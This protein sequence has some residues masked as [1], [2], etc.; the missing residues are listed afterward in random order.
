VRM[1]LS[2]SVGS[3][4]G[5]WCQFGRLTHHSYMRVISVRRIGVAFQLVAS[6]ST[7]HTK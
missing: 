1:G 3:F 6:I 7:Y 5:N 2:V 4:R